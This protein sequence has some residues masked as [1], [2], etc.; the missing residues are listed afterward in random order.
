MDSTFGGDGVTFR[1]DFG[2]GTPFTNVYTSATSG[3]TY[4][5]PGIYTV[6]VEATNGLGT[7]VIGQTK[8]DRGI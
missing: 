4:A 6:R 7:R 8:S 1:W 3:H 5:A 2:D